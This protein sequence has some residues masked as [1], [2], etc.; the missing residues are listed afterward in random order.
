MPL[1]KMSLRATLIACLCTASVVAH[2]HADTAKS[3]DVQPGDLSTAIETLAKQCGIYVIYPSDQLKGLKTRGVSG[4]LEP[5]EAFSKLIEGTALV[6][7]D[8]GSA[9]LVTLPSG[10]TA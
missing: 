7:E 9:L 10:I 4:T 2:A 6:L 3:V 8:E 5:K 1:E